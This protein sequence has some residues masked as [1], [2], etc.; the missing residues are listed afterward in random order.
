[1]SWSTILDGRGFLNSN[2]ARGLARES[3]TFFSILSPELTKIKE[4]LRNKKVDRFLNGKQSLLSID[5]DTNC[6]LAIANLAQIYGQ[7][8]TKLDHS[9]L[10]RGTLELVKTRVNHPRFGEGLDLFTITN[11]FS[12]E[13]PVF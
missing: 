2:Q 1:M 13:T 7:F 12:N 8:F 4:T 3:D 10:L 11:P 6:R 9:Y 5:N